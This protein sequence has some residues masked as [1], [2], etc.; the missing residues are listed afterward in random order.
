MMNNDYILEVKHL[1]K[2][3]PSFK[4][5]DISFNFK[6][7]KIMGFIGRNGAGKTTTMKAI[8]NLIKIDGGEILYCGENILEN[9]EKNKNEIGLLFGGLSFYLNKKVKAITDVTK[10][11]YKEFDYDLYQ[12]WISFFDIDENKKI[13]ELSNGMRVKYNL[14]IALSHNAK[15]LLLDEPTSGL[16][17]ISRDEILDCF[18]QI[19]SKENVTILFST[20]V[21]SDLDKIADD[22]T[23]IKEGKI[24]YTGDIFSF[25][26]DYLKVIGQNIDENLKEKVGHYRKKFDTFEGIIKKSDAQ[27]FLNYKLEE[28]TLEDIMLFIERGHEDEKFII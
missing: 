26:N 12:R 18:N 2:I 15:I 8:Y 23:Y 17:P 3:Y 20:H 28:A 16:D 7:N 24:I 5:N 11:F 6:R 1:T 10:R 27:L 9:E 14:A 4:L 22:I 13:K 21:I 19:S 25:K